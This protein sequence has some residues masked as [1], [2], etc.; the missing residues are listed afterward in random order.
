MKVFLEFDG[1]KLNF[2]VLHSRNPQQC[3]RTND[4][5]LLFY[6]VL[7]NRIS[8]ERITPRNLCWRIRNRPLS[9]F[10]F[11]APRLFMHSHERGSTVSGNSRCPIDRHRVTNSWTS[12]CRSTAPAAVDISRPEIGMSRESINSPA[13][14]RLPRLRVSSPFYALSSAPCNLRAPFACSSSKA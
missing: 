11:P 1:E 5:S 8:P 12:R 13:I 2:D 10:A 7:A 6:Q 14:C 9:Y 4:R 3:R